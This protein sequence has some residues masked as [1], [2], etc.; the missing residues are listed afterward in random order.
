MITVGDDI[1]FYAFR[2]ALGKQTYAVGSVADSIV[3]NWSSLGE[4][5]KEKIHSEIKEA[6]SD[7][8]AGDPMIDVPQW[9]KVLQ[10]KI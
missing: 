7:D 3:N 6:I 4:N 10:L 8:M 5:M 1:L 9:N 2:Y